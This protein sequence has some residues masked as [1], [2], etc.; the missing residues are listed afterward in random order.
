LQIVFVHIP[1]TAG[2]AVREALFRARPGVA[3]LCDY[4]PDS[5]ITSPLVS[6]LRY[7]PGG[8][9]RRLCAALAKAPA[10]TLCGHLKAKPFGRAFGP[11]TLMTVLRDPVQRVASNYRHYLRR[12]QFAGS[13]EAFAR[14][15]EI[16]NVQA[17]YIRPFALADWLFVARQDRLDADMAELSEMLGASVALEKVNVD[18]D[19][20]TQI[21]ADERRLIESLN[22]EDMELIETCRALRTRSDQ[23]SRDPTGGTILRA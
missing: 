13:L 10:F 3:N 19:G 8:E 14:Q 7:A 9:L 20:A 21:S 6:A 15:P 1:K 23:P 11:S 2:T 12:G 4:G 22:A 5:P 17:R 18:P 16:R